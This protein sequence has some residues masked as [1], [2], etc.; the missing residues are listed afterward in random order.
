MGKLTEYFE[1][2]NRKTKP[3][4]EEKRKFHYINVDETW[5]K[6]KN[7]RKKQLANKM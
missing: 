5:T 1:L 4:G 6:I 2:L 7:A 3:S